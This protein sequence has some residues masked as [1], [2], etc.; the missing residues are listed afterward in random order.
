MVDVSTTGDWLPS[1][2][3]KCLKRFKDWKSLLICTFGPPRAK[4][5]IVCIGKRFQL[6]GGSYQ[7]AGQ[8]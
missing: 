2:P 3:L 6:H 4:N 1:P 7:E 5:H 8:P